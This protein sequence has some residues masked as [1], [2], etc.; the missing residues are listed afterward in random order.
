MDDKKNL[1]KLDIHFRINHIETYELLQEI[2]SKYNIKRVSHIINEALRFGLPIYKEHLETEGGLEPSSN[3]MISEFLSHLNKL[4]KRVKSSEKIQNDNNSE[5]LLLQAKVDILMQM[6]ASIYSRQ[7]L[8]WN[9]E[10]GFP[11]LSKEMED[12]MDNE[13][14]TQFENKLNTYKEILF[15]EEED[16]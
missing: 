12:K 6:I 9:F 13:I 8:A 5:L 7:K 15:S 1:S 16:E 3:P 10:Q 11:E 4:Q 14:P 2:Q